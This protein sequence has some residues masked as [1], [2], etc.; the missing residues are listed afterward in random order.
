MSRHERQPQTTGLIMSLTRRSDLL[1]GQRV[2]VS[3]TI[4]LLLAVCFAPTVAAQEAIGDFSYSARLDPITDGDRSFISTAATNSTTL[5]VGRLIWRCTGNLMDLYLDADEYLND[6]GLVE[7]VWRFDRETPITS[8]W[9]LS[10]DG[11]ALFAGDRDRARFTRFALPASSLA[12]RTSDYR[13]VQYT[14][15]FSMRGLTR[16]LSRLMCAKPVLSLVDSSI[17]RFAPGD[18]VRITACQ[19]S[20][21]IPA[22]GSVPLW[23]T[24]AMAQRQ[25][26]VRGTR[27]ERCPGDVAIIREVATTGGVDIAHIEVL[28]SLTSRALSGWVDMIYLGDLVLPDDCATYLYGFAELIRR[29]RGQGR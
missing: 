5:R 27:R 7:V 20:G 21:G 22:D 2:S 16:A 18:R 3:V 29:C 6:E 4:L 25:G 1:G 19:G 9:S 14:Y 23:K 11:T 15:I 26:S 8:H 13:G 10:T 17:G 12:M 24:R 28:H